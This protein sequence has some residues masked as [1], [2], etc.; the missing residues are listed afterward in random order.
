MKRVFKVLK[1]KVDYAEYGGA[2]L[3]GVNGTCIIT[4]G[5]SNSKEIKNGIRVAVEYTKNGVNKEIV[6]E[7]KEYGINKLNWLGREK[8]F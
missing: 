4:H 8:G 5:N 3:I 7:L 6:D 2:P 1:K